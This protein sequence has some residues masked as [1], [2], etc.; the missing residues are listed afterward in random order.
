M[1]N[2]GWPRSQGHGSNSMC[3]MVVRGSRGVKEG[4]W[5]GVGCIQNPANNADTPNLSLKIPLK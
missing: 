1:S 4:G 2:C 3:R 5:E